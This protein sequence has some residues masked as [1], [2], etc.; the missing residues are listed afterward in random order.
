MQVQGLDPMAAKGDSVAG[1]GDSVPAKGAL[2]TLCCPRLVTLEI[3]TTKSSSKRLQGRLRSACAFDS[4]TD[5]P[6]WRRRLL[7]P[8]VRSAGV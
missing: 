6:A 4:L 2:S 8:K 7:L 1:K 5:G 3:C